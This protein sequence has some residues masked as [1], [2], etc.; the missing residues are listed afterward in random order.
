MKYV[1]YN[2]MSNNGQADEQVKPFIEKLGECE[3]MDVTKTQ[4]RSLVEGLTAEDEVYLLGGDGTLNRFANDVYGL[5]IEAAV[6]FAPTG[7][8]NDFINDVKDKMSGEYIKINEYV[9]NLPLIE[10]N[11]KTYRFINGVGYGL[12]GMCCQ[13]ADDMRAAGKDKINYTFIAIK[14][15]LKDYKPLSAKVVVDGVEKTYDHVW[16]LPT[17][18]GRFYGGGMMVAP[19]QD[20]LDKEGKVT[21]L[22][23]HSKSRLK[24][25]LN[26]PK[27]KSGKHSKLK[28]CETLTGKEVYI[29]YER[30][31]AM[32]IDGETVRDVKCCTIKA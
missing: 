29:E 2:P 12:D 24:T 7:T 1:L 27:I 6:Y 30:P 19:E 21:V 4:V 13:V 25:F 23:A 28:M 31:T 10:V 17:M 32:Q 16:I 22:I 11:G 14:L 3:K 26:F 9:K 18:K 20:R 8:G 15:L 5:D